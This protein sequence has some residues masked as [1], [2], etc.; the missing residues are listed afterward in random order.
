MSLSSYTDRHATLQHSVQVDD[1]MGSVT[2]TWTGLGSIAIRLTTLSAS[3]TLAY[4]REGFENVIGVQVQDKLPK[5]ILGK[6]SLRDL[7]HDASNTKMRLL[8]EGRKLVIVG[9]KLPNDGDVSGVTRGVLNLVC[10]E[11]PQP[12]GYRDA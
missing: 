4:K 2:N 7:L 8:F 10:T 12:V 5:R 11:H 6:R 1:G 9:V 3:Q